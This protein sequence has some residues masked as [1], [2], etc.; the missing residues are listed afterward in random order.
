M[1][2]VHVQIPNFQAALSS[3]RD[4]GLWLRLLLVRCLRPDCTL[5]ATRTFIRSLEW[6]GDRYIDMPPP[7]QEQ[8]YAECSS[9][10]P[11]LYLLSAGV[12]PTES[13]E[14]MAK[15]KKQTVV[16][17]SMG[18]GQEPMAL[19]A[20]QRAAVNGS[21]VRIAIAACVVA[22]GCA[23]VVREGGGGSVWPVVWAP[24]S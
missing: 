5:A 7:T 17:V 13:V 21:W 20:L 2:L 9:S 8:V 15:L 4:T 23:F 1:W 10:T 11:I 19:R 16:A 3:G 14:S 18:E 6:M 12:D 24:R 22:S